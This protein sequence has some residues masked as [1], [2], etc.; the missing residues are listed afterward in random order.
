MN[1]S[2]YKIRDRYMNKDNAISRIFFFFF[3]LAVKAFGFA[4]IILSG[5]GTGAWEGV[6]V[7]LAQRTGLTVGACLILVG[8]VI[9]IFNGYL[10]KH[11]PRWISLLTLFL[12]G[13]LIDLWLH[14]LNVSIMDIQKQIIIFFIG[15]LFASVGVGVYLQAGFAMTP[16][17][18]LMYAISKT[19]GTNL[20]VAKTMG[21][22]VALIIAIL[23]Q[24]PIGLGT[25]I[26]T[27]LFGPLI[28]FFLKQFRRG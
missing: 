28:Q 14:F 24:G 27:I 19:F 1:E 7:G 26:F 18:Q 5:I 23:L 9:L 3:G 12:L 16:L 8:I 25:I 6:Y 22:F 15:L 13:S 20:M 2:L 11:R 17:D 21:E 4:C 10:L